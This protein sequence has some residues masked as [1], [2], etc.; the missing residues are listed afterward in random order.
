MHDRFDSDDTGFGYKYTFGKGDLTKGIALA[1]GAILVATGI[2]VWFYCR[3]QVDEKM[4]VPL[5]KKT[6]TNMTNDMILAKDPK[7]KG[8]Q[9]EILREGRHFRNPYHWWWPAPMRATDIP[10]LKVGILIRQYGDPLP[11]GEV[12]A[13][14]KTEKGI[15]FEVLKT[16]LHYINLWAYDVQERPMVKIEP[17]YMGVVTL[18]AG[19]P[20]ED[21]NVFVVKKGER[22]TQPYLLSPGTHP[23]YSNPYVY[24]VTPIDVRS[25]KFEMTSAY[26]VTFLS[27]YGFDIKVDG[28]I[29]WAPDV[30]KL[31][32]L[33]VKYVD[34]YDLEESG[35]INN[36]QRK[37]ILP[38]ARSY[39]RTIGGQHRAVDYI[40][41]DTRIKVQQQVEQQL[42]ESCAAEGV[43]IRSFV[44][45]STD[46][47]QAIQEQYVRR[48]T[49]SLEIKRYEEEIKTQI[50]TIVLKGGEPVLGPD[51]EPVL[52]ERG[53][54]K[55]IGG[56]PK[57]GPD[58]R[59]VREGGRL[60]KVIQ[61][62]RKD[63]EKQRGGIREGVATEIRA[64]QQY[65]AVEV[66]KAEKELRVIEVRFEAAKDRAATILA[67]GTAQAAVTVMRNKAEAEAVRAKVSAFR[68]GARYAEYQL[69]KKLSP[70]IRKILSNTEGSFAKLFERFASMG[71]T[72]D[73][74]A[75]D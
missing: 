70:G 2:Y 36:I 66:T 67:K 23:E 52:D 7:F 35:G 63:R 1:V 59:P 60:A 50:G 8:P 73:D 10:D 17:G 20:T 48:E 9:F 24:K 18:M 26:G 4:F 45:G 61:E 16:G 62:R 14:K 27:K 6:G 74:N 42:K 72:E 41:G 44:I 58:G 55:I 13:K 47:P 37:L 54:P 11:P 34:E 43:L 31:S 71:E 68:T 39:V 33:F 40:T 56:K 19:D 3:I 51:G 32:E 12:I 21:P 22:G 28:T 30:D 29:E 15:V 53:N 5:V 38:F 75:T 25:Q 46:P 57:L 64:A 49:S 65:Q 69:I